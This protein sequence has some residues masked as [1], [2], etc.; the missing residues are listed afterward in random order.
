M[1]YAVWPSGDICGKFYGDLPRGT[2]HSGALN[3]RRVAKYSDFGPIE[4][5]IWETVQDFSINH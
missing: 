4:G 2:T 5:Y 3:E 1:F